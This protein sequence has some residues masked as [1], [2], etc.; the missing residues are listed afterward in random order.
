VNPA[1]ERN[2][3]SRDGSAA[4]YKVD[5]SVETPFSSEIT[6]FRETRLL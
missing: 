1:R 6:D 3:A 5:S 4:E 2:A